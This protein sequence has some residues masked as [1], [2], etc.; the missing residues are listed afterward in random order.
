MEFMQLSFSVFLNIMLR[1]YGVC[2]GIQSENLVLCK[3][4]F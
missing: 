3:I 4:Q 2:V 1:D